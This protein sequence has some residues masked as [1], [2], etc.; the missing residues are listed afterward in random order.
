M[1]TITKLIIAYWVERIYF[2]MSMSIVDKRNR[3]DKNAQKMLQHIE[4][5]PV[6][7]E[8]L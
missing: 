8:F 5:T 7:S 1:S 2:S 6:M 3:Y 4:K